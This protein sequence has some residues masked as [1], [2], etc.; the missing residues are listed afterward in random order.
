[1]KYPCVASEKLD[2][3]PAVFTGHQV[4]TMHIIDSRTRQG[5]PVHSTDH[6]KQWLWGKLDVG[7]SLV[8]E[9]YIPGLAFKDI[10]GH[11]RKAKLN[12][13][14]ALYVWDY[15]LPD[16]PNMSYQQR[17]SALV[18]SDIGNW[19]YDDSKG[20]VRIITGRHIGS[21]EE[22]LSYCQ[23]FSSKYPDKE[24]L[25]FRHLH[26]E[27]STWNPGKRSW[28][29]QRYKTEETVD[30]RL[31]GFFPAVDAKTGESK[32][33]AGRLVCDYKG[34]AI[35]VGP[36]ALSHDERK[37]IYDSPS[38]FMQQIIEVAYKPDPS[39]DALREA[40]FKRWRHDKTEP[41]Y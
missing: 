33:M 27:D 35:G 21:E 37:A 19:I 24:G 32:K 12:E 7:H 4:G 18:E 1:M 2:G 40:R 36:G 41:S 9:L 22:L 5:E 28:G 39:Y 6:I 20:P 10:S 25:I 17:M 16:E 8:G 31:T 34:K 26:G 15:V 29:F 3:V 38:D 13:N 11:V 23:D 30:L 14:I